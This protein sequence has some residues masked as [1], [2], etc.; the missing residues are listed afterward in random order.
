M[1]VRDVGLI[2]LPESFKKERLILVLTVDVSGA[3][4]YKWLDDD[5]RKLWWRYRHLMKDTEKI[6]LYLFA[7]AKQWLE[8][9][10]NTKIEILDARVVGTA[11]G[12]RFKVIYTA[13]EWAPRRVSLGG[14]HLS[15]LGYLI[16]KYAK[17]SDEMFSVRLE[18]VKHL[19]EAVLN[20]I[21]RFVLKQAA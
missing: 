10:H 6:Y 14:R 4:V 11:R 20:N 15:H 8:Q 1:H 12:P 13:G 5:T 16:D 2:Q 9:R 18:L 17:E 21:N 19:E 3:T 7:V